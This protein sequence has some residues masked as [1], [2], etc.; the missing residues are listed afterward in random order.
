M[1]HALRLLIVDEQHRDAERAAYQLWRG[2]YPGR[3]TV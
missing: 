1:G 3:S 2:G